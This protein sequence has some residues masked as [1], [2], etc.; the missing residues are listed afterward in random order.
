MRAGGAQAEGGG[1]A[2]RAG[3]SEAALGDVLR[4]ITG[5]MR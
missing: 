2:E 5:R 3:R 1:A 4:P